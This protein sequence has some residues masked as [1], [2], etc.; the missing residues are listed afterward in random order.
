MEGGDRRES[1]AALCS[2]IGRLWRAGRGSGGVCGGRGRGG[3]RS[4]G[5]WT[6]RLLGFRLGLFVHRAELSSHKKLQIIHAD[7]VSM[8]D[9]N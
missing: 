1:R 8:Q 2:A 9:K 3:G 5:G 6:F 4:G 7:N